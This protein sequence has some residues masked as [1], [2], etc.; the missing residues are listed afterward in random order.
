MA[1]PR[2]QA[3]PQSTRFADN[4][5]S[6]RNVSV[7]LEVHVSLPSVK[8]PG[9]YA[10]RT[11]S[12]TLSHTQATLL[13]VLVASLREAKETLDNGTRVDR[14]EHAV[15]WLLENMAAGTPSDTLDALLTRLT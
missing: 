5:S 3:P 4:T 12:A 13:H 11:L 7:A 8:I 2:S 10:T 14:P 1:H 6:A 9:G 15:A